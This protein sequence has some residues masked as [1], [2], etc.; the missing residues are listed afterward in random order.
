MSAIDGNKVLYSADSWGKL[1]ASNYLEKDSKPVWKNDKAHDGWIRKVSLSPD[2]KLLATGGGEPSRS[3]DLT[4]FDAA[5]G[6]R[7]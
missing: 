7:M 3:G 6:K 2:G 4:L 1:I 5:T